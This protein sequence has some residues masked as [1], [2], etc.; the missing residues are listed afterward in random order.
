MAKEIKIVIDPGHGYGKA[1][2][3]GGVLFNEGDQNFK[4]GWLIIKEIRRYNGVKVVSTRN[5]QY[6]DPSLSQRAR[7]GVGAD[8]FISTH[9]N[10]GVSS[11]TGIEIFRGKNNT[12]AGNNLISRICSTGAKIMDIRNRGVK[13]WSYKGRDYWGVFNSG[14][15]AKNKMLIEWAFHT[16]TRDSKQYL[17]KQEALARLVATEIARMYNLTLKSAATQN[18]TATSKKE[19]EGKILYRV[20]LGAFENKANAE[21]LLQTLAKAGFKGIIVGQDT[22][23]SPK[24]ETVAPK[25]SVKEIAKEV[26]LGKWGNGEE[27]KKRLKAAGYDYSQVQAEVN[28]MV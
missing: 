9:T 27:R 5:S 12:S 18:A 13:Y 24:S 6:D 2:N 10:A 25:K 26:I 19:E 16:N 23:K 15:N 28:R 4:L 7:M 8:L 22:Y 1:H 3:R 11:A 20:Q 17:A 14:N 21:K